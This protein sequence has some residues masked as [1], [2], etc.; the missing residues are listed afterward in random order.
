MAKAAASGRWLVS[1]GSP[2]SPAFTIPAMYSSSQSENEGGVTRSRLSESGLPKDEEDT[3]EEDENDEYESM[4]DRHL[5]SSDGLKSGNVG[6]R[7][8]EVYTE[9]E[10]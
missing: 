6:K 2:E 3:D 9:D 5:E 4:Y 10:L 7:Y 8:V 1:S